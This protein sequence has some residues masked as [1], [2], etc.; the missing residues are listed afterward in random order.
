MSRVK[1]GSKSRQRHKKILKLAK[2][3]RAGRKNLYRTANC[4]VMKALMYAYRDRRNRKR[5]MRKLW[6]VRINA[7]CRLNGLY[8][9]EFIHG[10]SLV[11]IDL[12]RKILADMAVADQQAFA[13][14][15]EK[16]KAHLLPSGKAA[17]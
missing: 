13:Q 4:A 8:Y 16:V 1:R 12:N 9:S 15:V 11:G 14:L 3:F 5:D 7:A 2:G 6:I 10:L 17:A